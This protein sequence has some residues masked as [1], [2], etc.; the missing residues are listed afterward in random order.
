MP[1]V[2]FINPWD[3]LIGPNRYLVEILRHAP[4]LARG[5]TVVFHE[6]NDARGEYEALG[7]KVE[8]WLETAPLRARPTAANAWE[9][10]RRHTTGLGRMI[11]RL[12][13][14][15]PSIV[16]TNSELVW[17]GGIGA[18]LLG[19]KHVQ[20][21]HAITFA[22]RLKTRPWLLR[23]YLQIYRLW[24]DVVVAVSDTLRRAL[25]AGSYPGERVATV[26]NPIDVGAMASAAEAS[27]PGEIESRLANRRPLIVS[28][29]RISPMKGQDLLAKAMPRIRD[30]HPNA[31][32]VIA[33]RMGS[34][35]GY[36]DTVGFVQGIQSYLRSARLERHVW[37]LGE[38]EYLPALLRRA[39][40][41]VQ[42][43]RT[44]SFGRVVAEA[45]VCGTPVV[46]FDVGALKETAGPGAVLVKEGDF[47]MLGK[48]V[49]NLLAEPYRMDRMVREGRAH[50]EER[51][52]AGVVARKFL[53]VLSRSCQE[54]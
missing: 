28:A 44:E 46:G 8:V 25:I 42:P 18:R 6:E 37:F 45:L 1:R 52:K 50:V 33:G 34:P 26:P 21:F 10:I 38:V 5:A 41:Y 39:D 23:A 12:Q 19:T 54:A 17:I 22:Y 43:S 51:F 32:C 20:V 11:R 48:A 35:G 36:E 29:G 40:I 9:T 27:L 16:V 15:K 30:Q 53:E 31:L 14:L 7:C 47:A 13:F 3:R 24:N 49:V 4:E 2:L